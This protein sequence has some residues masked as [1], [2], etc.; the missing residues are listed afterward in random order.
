[1]A[2]IKNDFKYLRYEL[3]VRGH[4]KQT[5]MGCVKEDIHEKDVRAKMTGDRPE[6]KKR[7]VG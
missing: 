4:A 7:I 3:T 5:W 2:I 6:W 1:M